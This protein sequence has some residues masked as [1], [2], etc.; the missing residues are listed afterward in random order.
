M[1]S[2][3][4]HNKRQPMKLHTRRTLTAYAFLTIP[5]LF[6]LS[7]RIFPTLYAFSL[8]FMTQDHS[9]GTLDNYK[10]LLQDPVFWKSVLNTGLYVI[11]TVPLQMAFGLIIALGIGR[12]RRF[13][14]LYRMIYFL[15]Y[16]T[17]IVAVSWV[18]R[19][20]YDQNTGVFNQIL[21][22]L[23]I[24]PQGFLGDP[25]ESLLSVSAVMIW[26][27]MGFSML[28][29]MAGLEAVPKHF[30]EAAQIDGASK[31]KMFWKIT[32][33]LL[34]P[35]IVFLAVTGV[36]QSLQSFTQIQNLTGGSA[37][38]A[39][40]P[41]NSTLSIVVYMYKNAFTDFNMEYASA[42]TVVL[43]IIIL[44]VTLIQL[45]ILNKSYEY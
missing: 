20:M 30:Y 45:R 29:F 4:V 6:F 28:I 27:A 36:I 9:S 7:I 25:S 23:H 16:I 22:W 17:S 38:N 24:P 37:A 5:L 40:G 31:W 12:V 1:N 42:I 33:P 3:T 15:P 8:S 43:F 2:T 11:V 13:R 19:L 34:N 21:T 14:W 26:Q 41:L 44:L 35:T 10:Q 32:F 39:G 18:W